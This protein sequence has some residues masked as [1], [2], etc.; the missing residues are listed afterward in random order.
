MC[1]HCVHC[2]KELC[3][4]LLVTFVTLMFHWCFVFMMKMTIQPIACRIL[5]SAP[6]TNVE[7]SFGTF[8]PMFF[9]DMLNQSFSASA[10]FF[11]Y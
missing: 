11:T 1:F 5:F 6:R 3:R 10:H 2:Q 7:I 9:E 4:E 8:N